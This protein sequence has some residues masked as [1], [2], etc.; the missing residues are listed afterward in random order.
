MKPMSLP[1]GSSQ[2]SREAVREL[3]GAVEAWMDE[4]GRA[5]EA[6]SFM[7]SFIHRQLSPE[8]ASLLPVCWVVC[9][10]WRQ[11]PALP[12]LPG[13]IGLKDN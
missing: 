8:H 3:G 9:C 1:R 13:N 6:T 12:E 10:E 4:V 5:Q 2:S 11:H 7:H